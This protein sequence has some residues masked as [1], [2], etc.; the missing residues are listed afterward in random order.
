MQR[1][2]LCGVHSC[3]GNVHLWWRH[4]FVAAQG[5]AHNAHRS[6]V[7][8][9]CHSAECIAAVAT[10]IVEARHTFQL[11]HAFVAA[12]CAR[13]ARL[14]CPHTHCGHARLLRTRMPPFRAYLFRSPTSVSCCHIS[15]RQGRGLWACVSRNI[16]MR[17]DF[18]AH[19]SFAG[20]HAC[21]CCTDICE[22]T[23]RGT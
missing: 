22:S 7:C 5:A 15:E 2:S 17:F 13:G 21:V 11:Q 6:V 8:S 23:G 9:G 4:A 18:F 16:R 1:V 20:R 12:G 10:S 19:L 14:V 3:R